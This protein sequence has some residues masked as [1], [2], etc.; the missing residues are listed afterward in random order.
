MSTLKRI[1]DATISLCLYRENK[2]K[3][4]FSQVLSPHKL[5]T[6]IPKVCLSLMLHFFIRSKQCTPCLRG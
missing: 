4:I 5:R 6:Q 1:N 3:L 2:D